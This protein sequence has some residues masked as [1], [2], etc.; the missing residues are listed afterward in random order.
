MA[1]LRPENRVVAKTPSGRIG[2]NHTCT[3]V[4]DMGNAPIPR[5]FPWF[6]TTITTYSPAFEVTTPFG[7]IMS[8][9]F[10]DAERA[11]KKHSRLSAMWT[12][13][14]YIL[15]ILGVLLAAIAGVATLSATLGKTEAG[16]IAIASAAVSG[17][18]VFL[19]SD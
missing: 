5:K 16:W 8:G 17:I 6:G 10:W 11:R 4:M 3:M 15:G 7:R 9:L 19:K 18:A 14:H 1:D 12:P 2:V 13:A